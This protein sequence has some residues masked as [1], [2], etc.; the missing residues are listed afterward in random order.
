MFGNDTHENDGGGDGNEDFWED[1]VPWLVGIG[2]AAV[3]VIGG[4]FA[5]ADWLDG[6]FGWHLSGWLHGLIGVKA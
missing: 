6:H 4:A 3:M 5:G 2:L 1:L